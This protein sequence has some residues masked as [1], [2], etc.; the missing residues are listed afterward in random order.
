MTS[1][2]RSVDDPPIWKPTL[3]PSMRTAA[4]RPQPLPL[5]L[6]QVTNPVP[7]SPPTTNAAFFN[8]GTMMTHCA[9]SRNSCGI[10]LSGVAMISENTLAASPIVFCAES[11]KTAVDDK[12][13]E[14][15]MIKPFICEPPAL[16]EHPEGHR[17]RD[18]R[19]F[20]STYGPTGVIAH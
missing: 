13:T 16:K 14:A 15:A 7:N 2:I 1:I 9:F 10:P 20:Q 8:P 19:R 12:I 11:A 17:H 18:L 3:A 5:W 6:R 4:G